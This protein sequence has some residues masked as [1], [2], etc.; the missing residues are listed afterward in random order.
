M[1]SPFGV[2]TT[3]YEESRKR[4]VPDRV[5]IARV[6]DYAKPYRRNLAIGIGAIILS[7]ITGLL[8]PYLHKV[9]IDQI[10]QP[11]LLSGFL[12]WIPLFIF[13]TLLNYFLQYV[14]VFQMR[15][16]GENVVARM[17]DDMISRLQVI[18]L[19]YFSEGEIGRIISRPINDA[20]NVRIFLRM[21]LTSIIVDTASI[22]GS[23]I[24]IFT[25]NVKL[26]FAAIAI[27]PLAIIV[28]W[29][30]GNF[31]RKAYRGSLTS[32]AGL[33]ARLQENLSGMK[34]IK[35]FVREKEA[36][37]QFEEAQ[38][39][40]F[41]ATM[42]AV[43]I[44]ASY[45]PIIL[46]MRISGT[47]LILWLGSQMV[48]AG[49][50]TIGTLVAFIE[51]QFS[52]FMPLMDLVAVYDQYQSA[53]AA[54]ERIFDLI[55]SEE[56]VKDAPLG[57]ALDIETIDALS[58]ENVTFGYD[59][60]VPVIHNVSFSLESSKKLAI[61]GPTGAGKSTIINLV[62]RFYDPLDGRILING[63][64]AK[65]VRIAS[66]RR[67]MSIVLQDSFL[68]PMSV[69]DNIRFGRPEASDEEVVEASKAVGAHEFIMKLPGGYD[70]V[71]Q[72]GSSN[73]S[74]GQRQ[75]ISFARTLLMNPKLLI[76]DE[77][78]SSIDPYTEL[79][80]QNALK[81]I[82]E[83]RLAIIIAHRLSTIRLCDEILVLDQGRVVERGTHR[84]LMAKGGL[85][86][87]FYR[88]QFREEEG[89]EAEAEAGAEAGAPL[90]GLSLRPALPINDRK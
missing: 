88:M 1:G 3:R 76:L 11:G 58:F 64:D 54:I 90:E 84:E 87:S 79:V 69:K 80:V 24:I 4:R 45:Q 33:T 59:P 62:A 83:N 40:V 72:E 18:S 50:I 75:L 70:Y 78:T 27:L 74:I 61:V 23:L 48:L 49:E 47:I 29:F 22:L 9:A 57:K 20:N 12:W 30:L 67:H 36:A 66:L 19:R 44:S 31:S 15:I 7:S 5:L 34:V 16:V 71:I 51:Y 39:K 28:A 2:F 37:D 73:I 38:D 10:I 52:Y 68:F 21:G 14:Q 63:H 89:Y 6:Y 32:I 46:L 35:S 65:N 25:L 60:K 86:S 53:M 42:R 56:E 17:R 43:G 77:A 13:V 26:A 85:Y 55:D 81:K 82:L 8:S 41:R